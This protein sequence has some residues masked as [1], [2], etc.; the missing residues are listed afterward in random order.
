MER[1]NKFRVLGPIRHISTHFFPVGAISR[2]SGELTAT[3]KQIIDLIE[4]AYMLQIN[5][6]VAILAQAGP[7]DG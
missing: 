2:F 6:S 1:F 4:E 3:Q 5:M 7:Q